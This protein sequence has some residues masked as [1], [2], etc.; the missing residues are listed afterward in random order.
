M[1]GVEIHRKP[2]NAYSVVDVFEKRVAE[3]SGSQ[4]GV[5]VESC[6]AA[7]FLSIKY[8]ARR[9]LIEVNVPRKTYVSVPLAVLN[10]GQRLRFV[11]NSWVGAYRLDPLNIWDGAKRFKRGMYQGGFHCLSFHTKKLIPIG[12]GGMILLNDKLAYEE[13]KQMRYDGRRG[14]PYQEENIEVLGWNMYMTPE[15]A[16]RGLMLL[17]AIPRDGFD[18][19]LEDYPDLTKHKVFQNNPM[20]AYDKN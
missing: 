2:L 16:S 13:L 20:V 6:T 12:R 19:Q 11:D 7:L 4:Y 3:F 15:Q 1:D 9:E 8:L 14:L 17:D 18:D 10:A 5:A